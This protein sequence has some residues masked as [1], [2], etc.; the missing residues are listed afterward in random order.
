MTK[1]FAC[2][3]LRNSSVLLLLTAFP[4]LTPLDK[5]PTAAWFHP[6][7]CYV[8]MIRPSLPHFHYTMFMSRGIYDTDTI[9]EHY[10]HVYACSV[11]I[12]YQCIHAVQRWIGNCHFI[13]ARLFT[14][15]CYYTTSFKFPPPLKLLNSNSSDACK[16]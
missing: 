9:L 16:L 10:K 3:K 1:Q 4:E 15:Y 6:L 7:F 14:I 12:L 2:F 11:L 5:Q 13:Q 8:Y